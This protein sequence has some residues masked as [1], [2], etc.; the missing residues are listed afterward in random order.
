MYTL[1]DPSPNGLSVTEHMLP[2]R[3]SAR[4]KQKQTLSLASDRQADPAKSLGVD[5]ATPSGFKTTLFKLV[6]ACLTLFSFQL[7]NLFRSSTMTYN[8]TVDS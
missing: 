7:G 6:Y 8:L 5:L 1:S 3:Q 4:L 2:L